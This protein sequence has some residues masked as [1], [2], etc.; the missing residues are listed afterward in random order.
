MEPLLRLSLILIVFFIGTGY[1]AVP[2]PSTRCSL[3][4]GLLARRENA[5]EI[6]RT[7]DSPNVE[8]GDFVE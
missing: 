6:D 5:A 7:G 8:I 2:R 1:T 3:H 4:A